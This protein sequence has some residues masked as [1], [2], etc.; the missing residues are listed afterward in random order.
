M[1]WGRVEGATPE[2]RGG[3][4]NLTYVTPGYFEA[5]RVPLRAGRSVTDAD[6]AG[7]LPVAIV[8]EEFVRRFYPGQS[9]IGLHIATA[10]MRRQIVGVV[11][12][13][14][15]TSSGLGGDGSPLPVPYI[16]YVPATQTPQGTLRQ[17]HTWFSPSWVIRTSGSIAG[18]PEAVRQAVARVDP[19][20]PIAKTE[21][22]AD[23]QASALASQRFMMTLVLG[24]G[25]VALLLAA[26]GIH[27]L[28]SSSVTERTRELGLRLALGASGRQVMKDVMLPGVTLAVIGALFGA[29]GALAGARVMQA[30]IW[31]VQPRDPLTF[32]TVI[33]TLLAVAFVASIL[34][35]LRV[36]RLDPALTL[37]AE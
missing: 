26:I 21:S 36:L 11:G 19:L 1:G 2:D 24:L 18:V 22:M 10:G 37:R 27:G 35:A 9:V 30:Y 32:V 25:A 8:N 23:V 14:R 16:V 5:L 20:L 6:T 4:T 12:N 13:T 17:V 31:G 34:P 28:I 29:A 15:V 3:M 7:S 33:I